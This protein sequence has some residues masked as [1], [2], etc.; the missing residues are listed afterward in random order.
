MT[1]FFND[2]LEFGAG[3][4]DSVGEHAEWLFSRP[5]QTTNPNVT[6]QPNHPRVDNAGNVVTRPMGSAPPSVNPLVWYAGGA[7]VVTGVVLLG[8]M[9]LKK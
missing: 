9:A 7:L 4:L 8:V 1:D 5:D 2:L 3:A 6:Q